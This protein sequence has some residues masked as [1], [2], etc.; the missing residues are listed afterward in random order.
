[1]KRTPGPFLL[2]SGLLLAATVLATPLAAQDWRNI[3]NG[4]PIPTLFYADQPYV[5]QSLDG[6]NHWLCVL[7]T[8][9][10]HEGGV[11][12][13]IASQIS[14]N[15]GAT[16]SPPVQ[17]EPSTGPEASWG[18]PFM[19]PSG[20][21]YVFYVYNTTRADFPSVVTNPPGRRL[22][23][24]GAYAYKYSDDFGQ[25]WSARHTIPYRQTLVDSNNNEFGFAPGAVNLHWGVSKAFA[26]GGLF[27]NV[28]TKLGEGF[29]LN[30]SGA[31]NPLAI[32]KGEG[33]MVV[34][35]NLL[36]E[37]NPAL[38][39][40]EMRPGGQAGI[41]NN[42]HGSVQE[43]HIVVPMSDG[44]FYCVYRTTQGY[45]MYTIS[46]NEGL[47]WAA[48]QPLTYEPGGSRVLKN[49]RANIK[50]WRTANGRYLLWHHNNSTTGFPNRNPAWLS[51]GVETN[52]GIRWSQPEI[53]LYDLDPA[54]RMSYPDLIEHNGRYWITETQKSVARVHEI[55]T[56]FLHD[57]WM[58]GTVAHVT[59]N[60]LAFALDLFGQSASTSAPMPALASLA[61]NGGF[62]LE[63]WVNFHSLTNG[64]MLF[65]NRTAAGKGFALQ[66]TNG[67]LRLSLN[68]GVRS[69][70]WNSD[71]GI[72]GLGSWHHV[73]VVVDGAPNLAT[74]VV[75]GQLLDGGAARTFGWSFF[76]N[77]LGDVNGSNRVHIGTNLVGGL[78]AVRLYS[79]ALRTSELV[80]NFR[81]WT[82]PEL[83]LDTIAYDGTYDPYTNTPPWGQSTWDRSTALYD[84]VLT[85]NGHLHIT[86]N[87]TAANERTQI[88]RAISSLAGTRTWLFESRI[89]ILSS[90]QA[91]TSIVLGGFGLGVRDEGGTGRAALLMWFDD[92]LWLVGNSAGKDASALQLSTNDYRGAGFRTYR[93]EKTT[94]A[95]NGA[96]ELRVFVDG[97][98]LPTTPL[99]Y[100][101][102]P[103][104]AS[105]VGAGYFGSSP[106]R[107]GAVMDYM[108]FG[109]RIDTDGDGL[110]DPE[111]MDDDGDGFSDREE[112]VA[113]T[114]P[115]DPVSRFSIN[116][117]TV[118]SA[119]QVIQWSTASN[120]R[121]TV[122]YSTNL[123]SNQ[124]THLAPFT[125]VSGTGQPLAITDE[126][127]FVE[128]YLR[129]QV[130]E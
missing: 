113:G 21:V 112:A 39:H 75:D 27:F 29:R 60:S 100:T 56:T 9:T 102:L 41:R 72:F 1:M 116:A 95:L 94:N 14:T 78:G 50:I 16:W 117:G 13:H 43:E 31:A 87:G 70:S 99:A 30:P 26:R 8:G 76:T 84:G 7:T 5:V 124:W 130:H 54:V 68:D 88:N 10:N 96:F 85:T 73:G 90:L 53:L 59:T 129:L 15:Q 11:G 48:P 66:L 20:R 123:L 61:S 37:P 46:T 98:P 65:N 92:G 86:D 126:T 22:D 91:T 122:L 79:R 101:S 81:A 63:C 125:N 44:R 33:W 105:S 103:V 62:T 128:R 89:N 2:A 36:T 109:P 24:L 80:A 121:Y 115:S 104:A 107:A 67:A 69:F 71:S 77:A 119:G 12:Q 52:G 74:F 28:F 23:T 58:Q 18:V 97:A 110:F 114:N 111:D 55:P 45:P 120:R 83:Q 93:I 40:W 49:P 108:W 64:Q 25:T 32:S 127:T 4:H 57:L 82:P 38:H 51:A 106:G 35:S 3:T 118:S 47:S 17:I 19:T 42:A 6:S 34:S